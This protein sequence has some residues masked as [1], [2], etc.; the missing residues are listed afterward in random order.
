VGQEDAPVAAADNN[1]NVLL[2]RSSSGYAETAKRLI[3]AI[4]NRGLVLFARIDHAAA[5]RA[6]GL[7]LPA[8]EVVIFGNPRAGTPLMRIDPRIGLELP[9]RLLIWEDGDG[10]LLGYND[11]RELAARYDVDP[12]RATLEMMSGVLAELATEVAG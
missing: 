11:P 6:A 7:E 5:A 3:D 4:A 9:L 10:T 12:H 1:A 8:E 2:T